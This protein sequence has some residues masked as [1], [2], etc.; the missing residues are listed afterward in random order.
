MKDKVR[1][2]ESTLQVEE[3]NATKGVHALILFVQQSG[4]SR[5]WTWTE[6]CI[7]DDEEDNGD[8]MM[9]KPKTNKCNTDWRMKNEGQC[10]KCKMSY[11][12][13]TKES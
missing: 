3:L 13:T 11:K 6:W 5:A 8:E 4:T 7:N 10:G 2:T 12:I 1:I 9:M